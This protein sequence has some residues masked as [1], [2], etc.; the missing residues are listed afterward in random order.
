MPKLNIGDLQLDIP[1]I[2]GGMSVGISL[3]GLAAAVANQGGVG[4]IGAAGIGFDE[5]DFDTNPYEANI[6]VLKQEI[7][8]ARSMSKGFI[9][10]NIMKA[11]SDFDSLF[12]TS[13]KEKVDMI[14]VGAGMLLA[15]PK[16]IDANDVKKFRSKIIPIV[17]S[18]RAVKLIFDF[19]Y[20]NYGRVPDAVVVEG[21]KAGGHL[22][23]RAE[24]IDKE[25]NNLEVLIKDIVET[26]NEYREKLKQHIPVIAAGGIFTGQD[27]KNIMALGADGV[28]MGT[29]FV[30]TDECDA[31]DEFKK[32]YLE[33]KKED[34]KIIKSPVGMPGRAIINT[35]LSNIAK[36]I[37]Y[38]VACKWKCLR[39][40]KIKNSDYCIAKALLNAK[41]GLLE[42]GFAFA[43]ANAF[44][45]NKIVKV[46][47][48]IKELSNGFNK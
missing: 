14:F 28:Q 38:P 29:R 33:A 46:K 4:V 36:G 42:N 9:G 1:I 41:Q 45:V 6:R 26:M 19:W 16:G 11:L 43:G 10:V 35:F 22:G 34:I 2:Q 21:P 8:K 30:A 39:S 5:E 32:T 20:K 24:D 3:S 25:E 40:C 31:S 37:K 13:L 7:A 18:S 12:I 48:L 27:I 15:M 23:F 47:E 17:S 44:R